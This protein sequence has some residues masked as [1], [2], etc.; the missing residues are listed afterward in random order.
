[1]SAADRQTGGVR[2]DSLAAALAER[3]NAS[4]ALSAL[5]LQLILCRRSV[6][7]PQSAAAVE[8]CGGSLSER[9][10]GSSQD[11]IGRAP[12]LPSAVELDASARHTPSFSECSRPSWHRTAAAESVGA[13]D[14]DAAAY[15]ASSQRVQ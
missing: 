8:W 9:N 11:A 12:L 13:D 6:P 14:N 4:H 3:F 7:S 5:C 10:H 2:S 1:M 15:S